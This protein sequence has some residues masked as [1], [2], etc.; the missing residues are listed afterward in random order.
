MDG[1][2]CYTSEPLD[3]IRDAA[4]RAANACQLWAALK[5]S[6]A[7]DQ[8]R[9]SDGPIRALVT[10][11][12]TLENSSYVGPY[13]NSDG[14]IPKNLQEFKER[15]TKFDS[16]KLFFGVRVNGEFRSQHPIPAKPR[17]WRVLAHRLLAEYIL[18]HI[19]GEVQVGLGFQPNFVEQQDRNAEPA[20][21]WI[22]KPLWRIQSAL[23]AYYCELLMVM[24]RFR[25]CKTC[26]KD[27]SHQ[28]D[29][30]KYCGESSTCRST[31]YH[32][33]QA[34]KRKSRIDHQGKG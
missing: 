20:P 19:S 10:I 33:R 34:A 26:G 24:R 25:A 3:L 16:T 7:T 6:Y 22:L 28:R 11:E 23:A 29:A 9:G 13:D 5:R 8:V 1:V 18:D 15:S 2:V 31:D 32:R 27:I 14:F 4:K 12:E 21:D 30:A 17:E